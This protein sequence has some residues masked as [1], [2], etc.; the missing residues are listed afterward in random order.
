MAQKRILV[1]GAGGFIGTHLVEALVSQNNFV[2]GVDLKY[3][4]F[5]VSP[6]QEFYCY[7]MREYWDARDMVEDIDEVYALAA[8]MGG[9]GF[10]SQNHSAIF[11]NNILINVNTLK[12]AVTAKVKRYFF[13]SSACIYPVHLQTSAR[14]VVSL[15]EED[16]YPADP[17]GLYG[18]EKLSTEQLAEAYAH[19]TDLEVRIARFHNVYGPLGAWDGGREKAPAALCRKIAE[20]KVLCEKEGISPP[21][22]EIE[23]WGDGEQMRSFCYVHDIVEGIINLMS[24]N[25][26]SP[27]NLGSDEAI[28]INALARIISEIAGVKITINHVKGPVGVIGRNSDNTRV[29]AVLGWEPQISLLR[30]LSETYGWVE[31]QVREREVKEHES[32]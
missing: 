6:A 32:H 31:S 8:D 1:T 7:D 22:G 18:W 19:E 14:S 28:S 21:S 2:R 17:Q 4:E 3:P 29:T 15:R 16:A 12:A 25:Y 27:L 13:S 23:V 24:S 10:I 20:L 9:M 30:G 11:T 26:R 5:S